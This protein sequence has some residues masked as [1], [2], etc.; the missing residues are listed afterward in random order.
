MFF[1]VLFAVSM[2][3]SHKWRGATSSLLICLVA[4]SGAVFSFKSPVLTFLSNSI[5]LEFIL[6]ILSY[7]VFRKLSSYPGRLFFSVPFRLIFSCL[8]LASLAYLPFASLKTPLGIRAFDLGIP[9]MIL[10]ISALVALDGV[11]LPRTCLMIGDASYSLYLFH[12]YFFQCFERVFHPFETHGIYAYS[13][14]AFLIF[15][16]C[17]LSIISYVYVEKPVTERLRKLLLKKSEPS[18]I[19]ARKPG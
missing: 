7:A 3:F 9:S 11:R 4:L 14:A 5:M 8:A 2:L 19:S 17:A 1:Y 13:M 6:G 15:I 18:A 16:C 10:F 12:P